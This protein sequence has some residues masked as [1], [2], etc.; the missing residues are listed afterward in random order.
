M[1]TK[2]VLEPGRLLHHYDRQTQPQ[3][4]VA[5]IEANGTIYVHHNPEIG[6]AVP[7]DIGHGIRQR[8]H[9]KIHTKEQARL[10]YRKNRELIEYVCAGMSEQWI[11]SHHVGV[12]TDVAAGAMM[13][14]EY[15][16]AATG[17]WEA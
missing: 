9:L 3:P 5:D 12:L 4:I 11:G 7:M 8:L 10:W 6:N 1:K 16:Q 14:L 15:E 17:Y 13:E 2:L